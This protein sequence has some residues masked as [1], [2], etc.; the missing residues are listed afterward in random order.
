MKLKYDNAYLNNFPKEFVSYFCFILSYAMKYIYLKS[1]IDVSLKD[2]LF[3]LTF[4]HNK[5]ITKKTGKT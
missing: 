4:F 2:F 1:L 3:L 5:T